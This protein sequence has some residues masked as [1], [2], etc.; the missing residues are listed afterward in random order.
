MALHQSRPAGNRRPTRL[1]KRLLH[2][3][4]HGRSHSGQTAA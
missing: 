2:R 4:P 1:L 3:L